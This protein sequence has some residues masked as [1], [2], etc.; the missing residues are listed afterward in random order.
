M[1]GA[2]KTLR[3]AAR[4]ASRQSVRNVNSSSRKDRWSR[5]VVMLGIRFVM[6]ELSESEQHRILK[7]RSLFL[8]KATHRTHGSPAPRRLVQ[9]TDH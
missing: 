8:S 2:G 5:C 1:D 9:H 6:T 4:V 3:D 7:T